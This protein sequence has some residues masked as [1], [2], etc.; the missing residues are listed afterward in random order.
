MEPHI[1][2]SLYLQPLPSF[3]LDKEKY[4]LWSDGRIEIDK[5][6]FT[7]FELIKDPNEKPTINKDIAERVSLFIKEHQNE[8][9]SLPAEIF[10]ECV[11][12]GYY[13]EIQFNNKKISGSNFLDMDCKGCKQ[14]E[15]MLT[16]N[17]LIKKLKK[18][19]ANTGL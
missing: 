3:I 2:F 12:D 7:S 10:N 6:L 14:Y 1:L 18:S 13:Y 16:I 11:Q 9:N 17:K 8:I 15:D 4:T 19:C 5:G